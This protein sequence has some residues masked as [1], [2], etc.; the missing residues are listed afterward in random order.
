MKEETMNTRW[1]KMGAALIA[2]VA[3]IGLVGLPQ[4]VAPKGIIIEPPSPQGLTA[5]VWVDQ[6]AYAV[7]TYVR[8]HF[9]VSQDAYVYIWDVDPN[10]GVCL[11]YPN[12]RELDN[13]VVAGAH[14]LPGPGMPDY[15]RV[16]EPLGTE[17]LQIVATKTSVNAIVQF[18]GGFT[19]GNQF[20]CH[21]SGRQ[22]ASQMESVKSVIQSQ[23]PETERAF[24]F[25]S[26]EVVSGT[27][28]TYGY[29]NMRSEPSG[30]LVAI[31]GVLA[32]YTPITRTVRAGS[33]Q[34]LLTKS[35]YRDWSGRVQV[36]AGVTT[37]VA[38][39]TFSPANPVAGAVVTFNAAGSYDP[40]GSIVTYTWTFGDGWS[41]SN[42]VPT[43]THAY[44]APGAYTVTLTVTD[45]L[46]TTGSTTRT[47]QVGVTNQPPVAA[48][49]Y[50]PANPAPGTMVLF[51][52]STSYDPNGVIT[53]YT[54]AFGDG[55]SG[56]NPNPTVSHPYAAPGT[57]SVTLTVTDNLGATGSVTR[58]VRVGTPGVPGTPVMDGIPGIFVWGSD[59]WHVTVNAGATWTS[60]HSYR[61]ELRTD[62]SFLG[63]NQSTSGGVAPLGIVPTPTDS[64]KTLVFEGS[65]QSGSI[66]VTFTV[67]GTTKSIWMSLKL[68]LDGNGTLEES[69]SL[70][71]LRGFMVHPPVVPFVVVRPSGTSDTF[72]PSMNF[73]I[74]LAHFY[75]VG[76]FGTA[77]WTGRLTDIATLEGLR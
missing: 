23:L 17:Y 10:G 65:L 29:L 72:V 34:V 36:F 44:G 13:H 6:A 15:L 19:P 41:G 5:R 62:G 26:F 73:E 75:I 14:T 60:A 50:S 57:Y 40:D 53:L 66:D 64:G 4:P 38:A 76:P 43:A 77:M 11:I 42:P 63:V 54:W 45:N 32:G 49:N 24:G 52:A 46:G 39:F 18:F 16:T 22:A 69:P 30:A 55:W 51:N 9:E 59:R 58:V 37:P 3:L 1:L 7:D 28:P 35:G 70:V 47:V 8:I 71:Y 20:T 21:P 68:D 56:S 33:H 67:A 25:T 74:H 2:L 48:F 31:D 27:V 12:Q 61:I